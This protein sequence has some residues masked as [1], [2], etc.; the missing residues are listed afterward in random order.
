[1]LDYLERLRTNGTLLQLLSHYAMLAAPDRAIWQDRLMAQE[2]IE[3][4]EI[5]KLHGE[6]IAFGWIE[7]NTD[8]SQV[9]K[10]RAISGCYR[11]TL[12]GLRALQQIQMPEANSELDDSEE[13]AEVRSPTKK[14]KRKRGE[15]AAPEPVGSPS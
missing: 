1:M 8:Y 3:P 7:Q 14:L 15:I 11:V 9:S 4:R 13:V 2:G 10:P 6:L 12:A 5:T